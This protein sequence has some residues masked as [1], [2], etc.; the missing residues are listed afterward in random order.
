MYCG[1]ISNRPPYSSQGQLS[2]P[3]V[4]NYIHVESL[5]SHCIHTQSHPVGHLFASHHEGPRFNPQGRYLCITGI[6]LMALSRYI[7]DPDM[8]DHCGLVWGG[9]CPKLSL[10]CSADNM[11]IPIDLTQLFCPSFMLAAGPPSGFT[12][13]IVGCWRGALWR[14]CNLTAFIHSLT[15]PVGHPFSSHHEGP[16][17]NPHWGAGVLMWNR[18]SPVSIVLLHPELCLNCYFNATSHGRFFYTIS[19]PKAMWPW[20]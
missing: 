3:W 7:G 5:Q 19:L 15:G 4:T 11:I 8:I 14:A 18:D 17:F 1:Q 12:T 6:L 16:G 10:G 9:L 20:Y 13:D 2:C